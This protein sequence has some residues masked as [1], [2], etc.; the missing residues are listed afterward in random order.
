MKIFFSILTRR[1][2]ESVDGLNSSL[3][4]SVSELW[5]CKLWQTCV[6]GG[7]KRVVTGKEA[8]LWY[9]TPHP[10]ITIVSSCT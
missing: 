10:E 3:A 8:I 2:A 1:L 4:E 5:H 9:S 7:R 6:S